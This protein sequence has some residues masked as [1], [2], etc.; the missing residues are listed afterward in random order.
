MVCDSYRG[1][2]RLASVFRAPNILSLL[3]TRDGT[4]WIGTLQGLASWKDGKLIPH[5]E[6]GDAVFALLEDHEGAV[7]V[8]ASG[9]VCSIRGGKTECQGFSGSSG[10]SLY[11]LYGNQ[12]AAVYSLVEGGDRRIWAGTESGLWRWNPGP[13]KR[14]LSEPMDILQSVAQGDRGSD[15]IFISGPEYAVRQ[16]SGDKIVNY[17]VPGVLGSLKAAHLLRDRKN[18]LWIGTYDEGVLRVS[19]GTTSRFAL[20]EGLSGNLV[21]AF[22]EDREGSVWVGTTNGLDRFREPAVSTLSA[23]QGLRSPVWS[24][25][26][27]Q[28]GS[29]WI[30]SYDGLQ[31]WNRGQLSIY[32]ATGSSAKQSGDERPSPVNG[33]VREMATPGL[34]D[35]YIGSLF[36]DRR[37][38]VWV[39]TRK[40]VAWFENDKFI[41]AS[42]LPEGSANAV[43]ADD[44]DGVWISYPG[45]GLFH[46][47]HGR[48]VQSIPWPWSSQ[49]AD[50]RL[51]AAV[52]DSAQGELWIGT[53]TAGIGHF[54]DGQVSKWLGSKDGLG[55]DLVWNLHLDRE[56]TLWA[57]TEGGLSAVKDGHVSTLTTKNGL[58]CNPVHWVAEDDAR[59]LWL[60][61]ACGLLRIDRSDLQAWASDAKHAIHPTILDGSDGFR[62]HAML[63]GYSPVVKKAPDGNLWFA[64]NDGVSSVDP[65]NLRLNKVPPPVHVEQITADGK[66]YAASADLRLPPRIRDLTIDYT[67]LSLVAPEKVRFRFK[68]DG[69]DQEW[70]EVVNVRQVQY[71]NLAPGWYTFRVTACNNS[72]V[73]NEVGDTLD[74]SIAPAY[75]QTNWFRALC[76]AA[77]LAMLWTVYQIRI[78]ALHQRHALL[79]RHEGEISALNER[80]MKAQEEERIR[81]AGELHDGVLQKITSLSLE[82]ATATL[83]LPAD[84]EPKAEVREVEKKL[85]EVGTEIRQLSHELHPAV[86]QEA[87]LPAA[88][89]SYCEEFSKLR[90]IAIA[91]QA[92]ESVEELSPGAAL[93]Y[94]P[95]R[96]GGARQ[97]GE[98]CEGQASGSSADAVRQSR[99][100]RGVG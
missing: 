77:F 53:I 18:A 65:R 15:L 35:N 3:A 22:F 56:G 47:S 63:T 42:G 36:E 58:P 100:P 45:H 59:A 85:I 7:W 28:D 55:A 81:I 37:G 4:L 54:K 91:Y 60:S 84:S 78:R 67:A 82:L 80:L 2:H 70:R 24:V 13:P 69:Q 34:P 93:V 52:P 1:V 41:R 39:T 73:W 51:S 26:P 33:T 16:L 27:A 99:L 94:L 23:Y 48:V 6:I 32:R 14:Y 57:A 40:G 20:G 88:L 9:R 97:R 8:G 64:H 38:R 86:L 25:L 43:I 11:Y 46:V 5:P 75:W 19:Q 61:T 87:G 66:T 96:A 68:L 10:T 89:S 83:E 92:D 17:A 49:E 90:G 44:G 31:R 76:V 30:G 74:F 98:T 12:G 79:E 50:P 72:G 62:M 95:H 21:T 29:L 71:S